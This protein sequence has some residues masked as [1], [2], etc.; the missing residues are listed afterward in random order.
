MKHRLAWSTS[1]EA[2]SF[3]PVLVTLAEGLKETVHPYAFVARQG[4]IELMGTENSAEKARV[5]LS[6]LIGPLR[7]ALAHSDNKV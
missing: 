3:D 7:S 6:K 1:P 2:V 5:V 4:F